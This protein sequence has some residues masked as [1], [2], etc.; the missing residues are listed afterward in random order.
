MEPK[1]FSA[2]R[3]QKYLQSLA[4]CGDSSEDEQKPTI[5][6]K[7]CVVGPPR[8]LEDQSCFL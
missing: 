6:C 4:K 5:R 3:L 8:E 1:E 7:M 2:A